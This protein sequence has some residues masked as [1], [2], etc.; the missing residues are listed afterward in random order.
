MIG[1]I[2]DRIKTLYHDTPG[3]GHPGRYNILAAV[4]RTYYWLNIGRFIANYVKRC[5][6]CQQMKV[7]THP[8]IPPLM[9][10]KSTHQDRPFAFV[11]C[12][13]ITKLS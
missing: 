1:K 5:A 7:N 11:T 12:D 3:A 10:I 8:T 4:S 9:P 2:C 6:D 13:F